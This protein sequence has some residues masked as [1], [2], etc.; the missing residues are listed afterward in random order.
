MKFRVWNKQRPFKEGSCSSVLPSFTSFIE[1][2]LKPTQYT[3]RSQSNS[4]KDDN[5]KS[6]TVSNDTEQST[7]E[8]TPKRRWIPA[9]GVLG[10]A[11]CVYLG[12]EFQ[13]Y[14]FT[15]DPGN[16][17]LTDKLPL[18]VRVGIFTAAAGGLFAFNAWAV[19]YLIGNTNRL[20]KIPYVPSTP[21]NMEA[22][23]EMLP[24]KQLRG[25]KFVDLGSGDGRMVIEAAKN[26]MTAVGIEI[27]PW[28]TRTAKKNA[29][30]DEEAENAEFLTG[31]L[32]KTDIQDADVVLFFGVPNTMKRFAEKMKEA[33]PG[34]FVLSVE[35]PIPG[36][37]EEDS[38]SGV[39]L[40]RVPSQ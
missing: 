4:P 33:K 34:T 24:I 2:E 11:S 10:V 14:W 16:L 28:L 39:Y 22:V 12:V 18:P 19:P 13:D 38:L 20:G 25:K 37:K 7:L 30:D 5:L 36:W 6:S 26:G 8:H 15:S 29:K 1:L 23:F 27:N 31:D 3:I 35:N 40:Y 21:D 9:V 17:R 32:W